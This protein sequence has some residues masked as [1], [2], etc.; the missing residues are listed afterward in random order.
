[1]FQTEAVLG[2]ARPRD[3]HAV[4]RSVG[5]RTGRHE[6]FEVLQCQ[7]ER[8]HR[9]SVRAS[10]VHVPETVFGTGSDRFVL[11]G[12]LEAEGVGGHLAVDTAWVVVEV[13]YQCRQGVAGA[14]A[15]VHGRD[16]TARLRVVVRHD[17][18]VHGLRSLAAAAG[19]SETE[20]GKQRC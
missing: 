13:A 12:A 20:S 10:V 7:A 15:R 14:W 18:D 2:I 3:L 16:R 8:P 5:S 9:R 1:M 17:D 6:S 4:L 19:K 11:D